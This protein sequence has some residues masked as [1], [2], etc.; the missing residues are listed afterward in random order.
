M[1]SVG[2]RELITSASIRCTQR[3]FT[4]CKISVI[5]LPL[6]RVKTRNV[7]ND[8]LSDKI[9]SGGRE[10]DSKCE[11]NRK[12]RLSAISQ[13]VKIRKR[14]R[15]AFGRTQ[16]KEKRWKWIQE[17]I[18]STA[19]SVSSRRQMWTVRWWNILMRQQRQT[20]IQRK[21]HTH[22]TPNA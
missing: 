6:H 22:H 9:W 2:G 4:G 19:A 21:C 11:S 13:V 1:L 16:K 14:L 12:S 18:I 15:N 3:S 5:Q 10:D 20:S 7:W 8:F 17:F